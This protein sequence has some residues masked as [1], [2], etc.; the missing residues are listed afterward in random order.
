MSIK[1]WKNGTVK[2]DNTIIDYIVFGKGTTPLV[3]LP[4]LGDGL[5]SAKGTAFPFSIM[6]RELG[7]CY[8]VYAISR[9]RVIPKGFTTKNIAEDVNYVMSQLGI[10]NAN[11]FGASM[12]GMIAQHLVISHPEKVKSLILCVT[13]KELGE[14]T[15]NIV[16]HWN[17]LAEQG[18]YKEFML[19]MAEKIYSEKYFNKRKWMYKLMGSFAVPKSWDNYYAQTEACFTHNSREGLS[20]ISCPTLIIGGNLDQVIP[21]EASKELSEAIPNSKL[22]IYPNYGHGAFEEDKKFQKLIIAFYESNS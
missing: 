15:K 20:E 13:T 7:K 14:E 6:Y 4:G 17:N 22:Y 12:G 5:K 3:I 16:K 21:V 10:T 2:V 1:T 9:R 19:D 18:Q 8:R 11:V